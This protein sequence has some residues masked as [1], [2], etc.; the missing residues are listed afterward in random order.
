MFIVTQKQFTITNLQ[1]SINFQYL[2]LKGKKHKEWGNNF[3]F[4]IEN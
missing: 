3:Q 2:N 4:L 1:F